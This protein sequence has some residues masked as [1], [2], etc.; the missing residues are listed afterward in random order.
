MAHAKQGPPERTS[1]CG[2]LPRADFGPRNAGLYLALRI[3]A[4]IS[5][6]L[7]RPTWRITLRI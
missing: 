2:A 5:G 4:P 6:V 1:A 7:P 3:N